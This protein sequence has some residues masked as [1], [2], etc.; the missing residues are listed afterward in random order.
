MY[1]YYKNDDTENSNKLKSDIT[2]YLKQRP[3]KR[4]NDKYLKGQL[5]K[6]LL[7]PGCRN[8]NDMKEICN[9]YDPAKSTTD[10]AKV[11]TDPT[12]VTTDLCQEC[13]E[14]CDLSKKL[15]SCKQRN[16]TEYKKCKQ[17]Q[18]FENALNTIKKM[19]KKRYSKMNDLRNNLQH[20]E[21]DKSKRN[22]LTSSKTSKRVHEINR[23]LNKI[24]DEMFDRLF[25]ERLL[26]DNTY[27]NKDENIYLMHTLLTDKRN[28]TVAETVFHT[29]HDPPEVKDFTTNQI[30]RESDWRIS[31]PDYKSSDG[32]S[33]DDLSSD[34]SFS[35]DLSSDDSKD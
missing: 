26:I 24:D 5:G 20:H 22:Y 31:G 32:S 28:K 18:I 10:P 21:K 15:E 27:L 2:K 35:D 25:G 17:C 9:A 30:I 8:I 7:C 16:C 13:I 1:A 23:M 12:K 29:Y 19:K 33:S 3:I 4:K 11:T 6:V 34:D 14:Q